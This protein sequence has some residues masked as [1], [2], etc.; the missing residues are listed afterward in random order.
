V[1]LPAEPGL[2]PETSQNSTSLQ[3][4]D[5]RKGVGRIFALRPLSFFDGFFSETPGTQ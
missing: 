2:Y 5:Y 1:Q 4:F 3:R